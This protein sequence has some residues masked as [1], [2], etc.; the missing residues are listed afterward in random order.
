MIIELGTDK[1][2]EL[3]GARDYSARFE[4][5]LPSYNVLLT[6]LRDPSLKSDA[7][8][9]VLAATNSAGSLHSAAIADLQLGSQVLTYMRV[10]A[11]RVGQELTLPGNGMLTS[12]SE[13]LVQ[14]MQSFKVPSRMDSYQVQAL[15]A[16]AAFAVGLK[17]LGALGPIGKIAAA[18]IGAAKAIIEMV[19]KKKDMETWSEEHR[20]KEIYLT[21][22]P[23]Q[24]PDTEVDS[25]YV[26]SVLR[27]IMETGAWTSVFGP[28]F[29]GDQW[30]GI[31]RNGGYA[32]APGKEIPGVDAF[33]KQNKVFTPGPGVGLI[34]GLDRISSVVQVSLDPMQLKSWNGSGRWPVKPSMVTDVGKFYVNTGRLASIAWGWA[35]AYDASPDLYKIDVGV[36]KGPGDKHLHYRWKR[37]CDGGIRYMQETSDDWVNNNG[38]GRALSGDDGPQYILGT[39]IGCAVGGWRCMDTLEALAQQGK[40][41]SSIRAIATKKD[42][43]D[44]EALAGVITTSGRVQLVEPGPEATRYRGRPDDVVAQAEQLYADRRR[45]KL[46]ELIAF[47]ETRGNLTPTEIVGRLFAADWNLDGEDLDQ[48]VPLGD[49]VTGD[50][51]PRIKVVE[52]ARSAQVAARVLGAPIETVQEQLSTQLRRLREVVSEAEF[53]DIQGVSPRQGWTPIKL[54][55]E[56]LGMAFGDGR[57]VDLERRNGLAQVV[58]VAYTMLERRLDPDLAMAIGWLNHDFPYFQPKQDPPRSNLPLPPGSN[59]M[60]TPLW[61]PDPKNPEQNVSVDELRRRW[62]VFYESSFY[63]WASRD[64]SRKAAIADNYNAAFRGYIPREYTSEEL[65]IAR[66]GDDITLQPHQAA[67]ARRLL[68]QRGGLL[69]FDVGVGKTYTAIAV[70]ARARQEGWA[71]RPVVLVPQSLVWKWKRDFTRCLPDFRVVVIGSEL[72]KLKSGKR[73]KAANEQLNANEI[74]AEEHTELLTVSRTD[75]SEARGDKWVAFQS[76]LYDVAIVSN[77]VFPRTRVREESLERY[78]ERTEAIMRDVELTIRSAEAKDPKK[79]TERQKAIKERGVRAWVE[80]KVSSKLQPDP[81]IA[82]EDIGVDLLVADEAAVFKNLHMPARREGGVPRYMGGGG[83]DGSKR[84]WNFDFRAGIVR[85]AT[86]GAGIV[87]LSATP[88]KNS[89]LEFYNMIQFIDGDVWS[90]RG[91]TDPEMFIDRYTRIETKSVVTASFQVEQKPAVVGFTH[92]D[93]LRSIVFRYSEWRKAKDVGIELPKP[94]V[95]RCEVELDDDQ[96]A[97]YDAFVSQIEEALQ[98]GKKVGSILGYLARL[99]LVA[100]HAQGDEGYTWSTAMG[101]PATRQISGGSVEHWVQNQGWTVV[102]S[103]PNAAKKSDAIT[104]TKRLPAPDP[105]SPKFRFI[106]QRVVAQPSCGHIIFCEPTAAH[107]WI[108][109]VLIDHGVPAERIAVLNADVAKAAARVRIARDFNGDNE[110]GVPKYDVVIANSVAYEGIDLQV[111]TCAIHHADLPWTP[112]DLEQRNGR[113]HRQGNTWGTLTIYY[114]LAKGSMDLFRYDLIQGKA[115]WLDDLIAGNP[116]TSN[117]AAQAELTPED[118]LIALSGDPERTRKLIEQKRE[119]DQE[120]RR[121]AMLSTANRLLQRASAQF[122]NALREDPD[123]AARSRAEGEELLA[124]LSKYPATWP[125]ASLIAAARLHPIALTAPA[126]VPIFE[127]LRLR[128]R[129]ATTDLAEFFEI[130]KQ[131]ASETTTIAVRQA[132]T[133]VWRRMHLVDLNTAVDEGSLPNGWDWPTSDLSDMVREAQALTKTHGMKEVFTVHFAGA[134]DAF[135]TAVWPNIREALVESAT[136]PAPVELDGALQIVETVPEG[137]AL[138][139]WTPAGYD[140]FLV[141]AMASDL[142]VGDLVAVSRRW[143]DRAF[144]RALLKRSAPESSKTANPS[145]SAIV[146]AVR[147]AERPESSKTAN[148]S[149]SAIVDAVRAAERAQLTELAQTPEGYALLLSQLGTLA[150][151]ED[152]LTIAARFDDE[153]ITAQTTAYTTQESQGRAESAPGEAVETE[154]FLAA[155]QGHIRETHGETIEVR[156]DPENADVILVVPDVLR[157]SAAEGYY[158]LREDGF[159]ETN[160][161]AGASR[162][163][164]KPLGEEPL[165]EVLLDPDAKVRVANI[166]HP[167]NKGPR[168]AGGDFLYPVDPDLDT[169]TIEDVWATYAELVRSVRGAPTALEQARKA[170]VH[171]RVLVQAPKCQGE[172]QKAALEFLRGAFSY[173]RNARERVRQGAGG[174]AYANLR[175]VARYLAAEAVNLADSCAA[176]QTALVA[177]AVIDVNNISD[178]ALDKGDDDDDDDAEAFAADEEHYEDDDYN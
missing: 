38:K 139:P 34:P 114:Y 145:E 90:S 97:K 67:G 150:E 121:K 28:R 65:D 26:E 24:Q 59:A 130:G 1:Y 63:A 12:M 116:E 68:A 5:K 151:I 94:R 80:D 4:S 103:D 3:F 159:E 62:G 143:W 118:F 138:L 57:R 47:H 158:V 39:G 66:W 2:K 146:D 132:G 30:I 15:L 61:E 176:G 22:P 35:T 46:D 51:W 8:D 58:G 154:E 133:A 75:S 125:Y 131:P 147:A 134:S 93:E 117:P 115:G 40:I 20:E 27:P 85:K 160:E 54:V 77:D 7:I 137:G 71:R 168:L 52:D 104:I 45:L 36:H 157:G 112:A 11:S 83:R 136:G 9:Q 102:P 127:G 144:P 142:K 99:G 101:G 73:V 6:A 70:V 14:T 106:A 37:Y 107:R 21:L 126:G 49:Y 124:R 32:F 72:H 31:K 95:C 91:I 74:T 69:A 113:A 153:W 86:G 10:A 33:G 148:P 19:I 42:S 175:K 165:D 25:Y 87:L 78:A 120:S 177:P 173:Y 155:I 170:L 167:E 56:W 110:A 172:A 81:R 29:D 48:L 92:L 53:E 44:A 164:V 79:L 17:G 174:A 162:H 152:P 122:A 109:E 166:E 171:A 178:A 84:A 161:L 96:R 98:T 50:L 60:V 111:R 43:L 119:G 149:E 23:L 105:E 64:P 163:Y 129:S 128:R 140:R 135:R 16:D 108:K 100:L 82:W 123:R 55:G 156:S 88:A 41:V 18:I 76:G 169:E 13:G 141:L 89:P